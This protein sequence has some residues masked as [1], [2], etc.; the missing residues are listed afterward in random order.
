MFYIGDVHAVNGHKF[1]T[2]YIDDFPMATEVLTP[3]CGW[4]EDSHN[5]E[6]PKGCEGCRFTEFLKEVAGL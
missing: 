4:K 6:C 1:R 5:P 2:I 3:N